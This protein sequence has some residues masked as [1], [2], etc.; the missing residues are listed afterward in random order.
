MYRMKFGCY[1][2]GSSV[3]GQTTPLYAPAPGRRYAYCHTCKTRR[4]CSRCWMCY[5]VCDC[6]PSGAPAVHDYR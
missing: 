4:L 5:S 1:S 6:D 3:G 2:I